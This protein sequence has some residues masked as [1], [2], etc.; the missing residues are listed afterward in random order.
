MSILSN[1]IKIEIKAIIDES[2]IGH[3]EELKKEIQQILN[4]PK[5]NY[6]V[7]E[8]AQKLSVTDLTVRNYISKGF[9]RAEKIGR[10]V[11]ISCSELDKSLKEIKSIKYKR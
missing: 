2:L 11:L 9:I 1:S 8:V 10:R 3:K 6:T 4:P 5:S 7:K